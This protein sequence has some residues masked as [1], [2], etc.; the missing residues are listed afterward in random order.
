MRDTELWIYSSETCKWEEVSKSLPYLCYERTTKGS[1]VIVYSFS[2]TNDKKTSLFKT[3]DL[4]ETPP[5]YYYKPEYPTLTG[6]SGLYLWD[7]NGE[8]VCSYAHYSDANKLP[9]WRL[10][11]CKKTQQFDWE[12]KDLSQQLGDLNKHIRKGQSYR[13][14]EYNPTLKTIYL[15]INTSIM[16]YGIKERSLD[17]VFEISEYEIPSYGLTRNNAYIGNHLVPYVYNLQRLIDTAV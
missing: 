8:L 12:L 5:D 6:L 3:V 4:L 7:Y 9:V 13:I 11:Y 17:T 2:N 14:L 15:S 1:K 10:N 16:S